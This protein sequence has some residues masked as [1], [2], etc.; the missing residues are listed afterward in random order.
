M[1][2][3]FTLLAFFGMGLFAQVDPCAL[4][5]LCVTAT[6]R[7]PKVSTPMFVQGKLAPGFYFVGVE[8]CSQS[9][10]AITE[11]L[12][13]VRQAA[14]L[15]GISILSN[16][17]AQAVIGHAQG[18]TKW[19]KAGRIVF[20]VA[21]GAAV[22]SGVAGIGVALKAGLTGGAILGPPIWSLA[23]TIPVSNPL[24]KYSDSALQ[25]IIQFQPFGCLAKPGIQLIQGS[26]APGASV[27]FGVS[28]PSEAK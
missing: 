9:S 6:V 7:D 20:A 18:S 22:A 15:S 27:R 12:G 19:A 24:D 2:V 25:E 21:G 26:V 3:R 5:D 1:A 16:D 28:V 17:E 13:H 23:S 11:A 8:I 14:P 10:K 4:H